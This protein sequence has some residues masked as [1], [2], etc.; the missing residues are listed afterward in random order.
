MLSTVDDPE[1]GEKL[2][3]L[4]ERAVGHL[5]RAAL[6]RAHDPRLFRRGQTLGADELAGVGQL[7]VEAVHE[8]D[9]RLDVVQRPRADARVLPARPRGVHHQHVFHV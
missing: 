7:L 8:L 4:G 1:A 3:R 5:G 2:L 9:V 6:P